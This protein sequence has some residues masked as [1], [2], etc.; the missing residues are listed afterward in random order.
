MEKITGID[1]DLSGI[2]KPENTEIE[3]EEYKNEEEMLFVEPSIQYLLLHKLAD[4]LELNEIFKENLEEDK[5][6]SFMLKSKELV[7]RIFEELKSEV[8][9]KNSKKGSLV[10]AIIRTFSILLN[11]NISSA[12]KI[13][14]KKQKQSAN[15]VL[16]LWPEP[17]LRLENSSQAIPNQGE[18]TKELQHK[19]TDNSS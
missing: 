17:S 8:G 10:K 2:T 5:T 15:L 6:D 7:E 3:S 12:N 13:E 4:N 1:K 14:K 16:K 11:A 19:E 9:D 18:E